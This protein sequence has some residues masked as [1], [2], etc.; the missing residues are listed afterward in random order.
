MVYD[1]IN[2]LVN[3]IIEG[4]IS[5]DVAA[6]RIADLKRKDGDDIFPSIHFQKKSKP[7]DKKYFSKLKQMNITG[8]C[9]E[10]FLLHMAEVSEYMMLRK[11]KIIGVIIIVAIVFVV[12]LMFAVGCIFN[13]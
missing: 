5:R 11:K 8:A 2:L 13:L 6:D 9:S 4:K 12:I 10:E 1:E 7:W 3:D